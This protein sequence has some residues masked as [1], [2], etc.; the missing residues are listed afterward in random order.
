MMGQDDYVIRA[1]IV[2]EDA[3]APGADS[4]QRRLEAV[5]NQAGST[6]SA[7]T[8]M[9]G[10]IGGMAGI[11]M[12]VKGILGFQSTLEDAQNGLATLYSALA[13]VDIG[14]GFRMA[15]EDVAGLRQDAAAGIGELSDY[16]GTFNRV[17]GA[18]LSMGASRGQ[19]RTLTKETI[20][21]TGAVFGSAGLSRAPEELMMAMEGRANKRLTPVIGMALTAIH[22]TDEAFNRL[23]PEARIE[24]LTRALNTFGPG[25][26]LMGQSWNAQFSTLHDTIQGLIGTV[27]K[28]LFDRWKTELGAVNDWLVKNKNMLAEIAER[29]GARLLK[30][31]DGLVAR[32]GTYAAL[33]AAS[34]V[35]SLTGAAGAVAGGAR[36]VAMPLLTG[37]SEG[38]AGGGLMGGLSGLSAAF[39]ALATPFVAV[40]GAILAVKGAM[41][42]YPSVLGYV[43]QAGGRLMD[44][45][46]LLG[47]AMDS[48]TGPGSALNM[49]GAALTGPFGIF[50]D[51]LGVGVRI[52]AAFATGIGVVFSVIGNG[53]QWIY[54][55][56]AGDAHGVIKAKANM[57]NAIDQA[58][59]NL[60]V[61]AGFDLQTNTK[62]GL[63]HAVAAGDLKTKKGGDSITNISGPVTLQIKT[64]V[65]ADPARV[66]TALGEGLD[67][68]RLAGLQAR[69]IPAA[70]Q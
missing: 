1:R 17:L 59:R 8:R 48:L 67:R 29:W 14:Q 45:F 15:Q 33:V 19:L 68:I 30:V 64:E 62:G 63:D 32:A 38:V 28:P 12:A 55:L 43:M 9:F 69:R 3:A 11:G 37:L 35:G 39:S 21:A 18:G 51:V 60:S 27:T 70:R 26:A 20:T 41:S 66:M 36:A 40:T 58:N 44:S 54:S 50:L 47:T 5:E 10:L 6:G 16:L 42:D 53:L 46:G 49:I 52:L 23:K 2:A 31:W 13:G 56:M 61:L 25:V 7:L 34:Q 24:A 22:M 65:N 57:A 4:A